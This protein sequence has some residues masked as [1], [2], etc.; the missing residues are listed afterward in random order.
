MRGAH[1]AG[2]RFD[3]RLVIGVATAIVIA[4]GASAGALYLTGTAGAPARS[5]TLSASGVDQAN[6]GAQ[7]DPAAIAPA[8]SSASALPSP[9]VSPPRPVAS[10]SPAGTRRPS[11]SPSRTAPAQHPS[12]PPVGSGTGGQ[13]QQVLRLTNQQRAANGGLSALR[14]NSQL[15][16]AAQKYAAHLAAD[17][18]FSHTDGSQLGD[19][20]TAAGYAWS[21][22]G[23]NLGLGQRTPDE[24]VT[25]WMNSPGHRANILNGAFV[26][27]GV[28]IAI[29]PDGQIIWCLDLG[30]P[31]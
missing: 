14:M 16:S 8:S 24:I 3:R 23:E 22:V 25:A 12:T 27:A 7:P 11:P 18:Q 6:R 28:G 5:A 9:S 15:Q 21:G 17:G 20:V 13:R 26:D 4:G 29:R 10:R 31:R 30:T 1:A 19:R 2:H